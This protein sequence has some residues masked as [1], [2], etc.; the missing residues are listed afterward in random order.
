MSQNNADMAPERSPGEAPKKTGVRRVNNVP[1]FIL[2]GVAFLFIIVMMIV[3]ADRAKNKASFNAAKDDQQTASSSTKALAAEIAGNQTSG[4]I[5]PEKPVKESNDGLA[6]P[7][8]VKGEGTLQESQEQRTQNPRP[9][10]EP[11][12]SIDDQEAER[13]RMEKFQMFQQ[14]VLSKTSVPI[15]GR[16]SQM[17]GGDIPQSRI[18]MASRIRSL[19][20]QIDSV[21]A[22]PEAVF[23]QR[24]NM[25]RRLAGSGGW[26]PPMFQ[27]ATA[28]RPVSDEYGQFDKR[29]GESRWELNSRIEAPKSPY[30]LRA[31]AVIPAILIRGINSELPGQITAQIAIDVYDTATGRYLLCPQGA[32][33]VGEYSS[34]VVFGQSR[35]LVAWQRITFPDGKVIDIGSMQGADSAGYSG[36]KD[37][38]NN[39]YW[40][41][42]GSALLMSGVV[43]GV[44]LSQGDGNGSD[45]QRAGDAMSEA[46][47]QQLGQVTA[48]LV[49]KNLNVAPTLEIRPGYRFNIVVTKD[50]VLEPYEAF[51]Y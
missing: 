7:G 2:G 23:N 5:D 42:Y 48:Q 9:Y 35:V 16:T 51:N 38:V 46:L 15:Q 27:E 29:P 39:H 4:I 20:E 40:R 30:M 10:R 49:T 24:Y 50:L 43:A 41:I 13:I 21:G 17:G 37:R 22:D 34:N 11:S 1:L 26:S 36:F 6:Y 32:E 25:A 45:S 31:G 28:A 19:G 3:A 47:G 12:D 8:E 18:E 44:N 14:A 33:A